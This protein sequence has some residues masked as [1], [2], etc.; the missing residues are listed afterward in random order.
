MEL[1][2][3]QV[4][5]G[6]CRAGAGRLPAKS[7]DAHFCRPPYNLQLAGRA[8]AAQHDPRAGVE[9]EWDRFQDFAAYDTFTAEWLRACRRVLKD[10]GTMWVIGTYH[11]IYRVGKTLMDLGYWLLNDISWLKSNPM[12]QFRG[13]RFANA[14]ETLL[15]AKKSPGA[16]ALHL[17]LPRAEDA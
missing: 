15:W 13:V 4:L 6:D 2:L 10:T 3:D 16:E 9:D 11:N 5:E 1:P 7:V 17:Q 8:M 14:H 12:P